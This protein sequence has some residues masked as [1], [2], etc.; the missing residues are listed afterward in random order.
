[1]VSWAESET[2]NAEYTPTACAA[3]IISIFRIA[4]ESEEEADSART[5]ICGLSGN[6]VFTRSLFPSPKASGWQDENWT[7]FFGDSARE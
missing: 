6:S 4:G 2:L 1:L 3:S 7:V 5:C